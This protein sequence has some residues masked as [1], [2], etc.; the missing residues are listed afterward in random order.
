MWGEVAGTLEKEKKQNQ[1]LFLW[2]VWSPIKFR[3]AFRGAAVGL[4]LASEGTRF[5]HASPSDIFLADENTCWCSQPAAGYVTT[6]KQSSRW[7]SVPCWRGYTLALVTT[8]L[9]HYLL[10]WLTACKARQAGKASSYLPAKHQKIISLNI[11]GLFNRGMKSSQA[12]S[13]HPSFFMIFV[14]ME[15]SLGRWT[16]LPYNCFA[17]WFSYTSIPL[18]CLCC[19]F[20]RG[21]FSA[22]LPVHTSKNLK[23]PEISKRA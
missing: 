1:V 20:L 15:P 23:N 13:P 4:C 14:H 17:F 21:K 5:P 6:G 11:P 8:S 10:T 19:L 3:T 22:C 12:P 18:K 2:W 7:A 16:A 9:H